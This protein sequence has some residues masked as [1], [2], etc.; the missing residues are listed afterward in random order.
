[1]AYAEWC[2]EAQRL[3]GEAI[4]ISHLVLQTPSILIRLFPVTSETFGKLFSLPSMLS[5]LV[6]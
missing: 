2:N 5:K 6:R 4:E 1:M 3:S